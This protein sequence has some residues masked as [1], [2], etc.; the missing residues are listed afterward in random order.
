MEAAISRAA[1]GGATRRRDGR[2]EAAD[3][4]ISRP[5]ARSFDIPLQRLLPHLSAVDVAGLVDGDAFGAARA[6]RILLGIRDERADLA[7]GAVLDA[8][9]ADA[10]RPVGA[11]R[12]DF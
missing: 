10:A 4:E 8:A 3:F 9:D 1:T 2:F 6:R 11:R 5:Y 12:R 7:V